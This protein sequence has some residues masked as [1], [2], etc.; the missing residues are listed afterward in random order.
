M[1][2]EERAKLL[3][4]AIYDPEFNPTMEST[5]LEHF[6]VVREEALEEAAKL[7]EKSARDKRMYGFTDDKPNEEAILEGSFIAS[8]IRGLKK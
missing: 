4:K 3:M 2:L 8:R 1:T 5:Y 7:A 6:R